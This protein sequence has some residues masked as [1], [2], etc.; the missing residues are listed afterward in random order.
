MKKLFLKSVL[1]LTVIVSVIPVSANANESTQI[2]TSN[3]STVPCV[4]AEGKV[5]YETDANGITK[6][7]TEISNTQEYA[8]AYNLDLP[9]PNAK[10]VHVRTVSAS[11]KANLNILNAAEISAQG[12]GDYYLKNIEGPRRGCGIHALRRD[13]LVYPGGEM[14]FTDS[15]AASITG[16]VTVDAQIVSAAVGFNVTQT[17]SV[18]DKQTVTI[19]S[20]YSRAEVSAYANYDIWQYDIYKKGIFWDS[21]EGYGSVSKPVGVCFN[22]VYS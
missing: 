17:F 4:K 6:E 8:K 11:E 3:S 9:S 18:T 13:N 7:I 12:V 21:K 20:N 14:S 15:V 16:T 10:I 19:P 2:A 5:S 22:I 1:A